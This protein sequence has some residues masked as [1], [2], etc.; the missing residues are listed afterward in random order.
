MSFVQEVMS[1]PVI[2]IKPFESLEIAARYMLEKNVRNLLVI[3]DVNQ[4]LGIITASDFTSYVRENSDDEIT[5]VIR[6]V[7]R[8]HA[9]YE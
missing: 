5:G 2:T 7:L 3:N 9:R 6:Q 1:S 4:P 8:E